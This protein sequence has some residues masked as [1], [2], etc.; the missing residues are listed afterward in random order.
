MRAHASYGHT[1]LLARMGVL[2]SPLRVQHLLPAV[3]G[4]RVPGVSS[5]FGLCVWPCCQ[6]L[7][8]ESVEGTRRSETP[9]TSAPLPWAWV[10]M[11]AGGSQHLAHTRHTQTPGP[12]RHMEACAGIYRD[13]SLLHSHPGPTV[14]GAAWWGWVGATFMWAWGRGEREREGPLLLSESDGPQTCSHPPTHVRMYIHDTVLVRCMC[15][16]GHGHDNCTEPCPAAPLSRRL[17]RTRH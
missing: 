12:P 13:A 4:V 1:D 15:T 14:W 9:R 6:G 2:G 7:S 10:K 11:R 5:C 16:D 3:Q 17:M 8:G